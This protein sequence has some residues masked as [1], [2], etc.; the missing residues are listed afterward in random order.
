MI[1]KNYHFTIATDKENS[2]C[3][4]VTSFEF[5]DGITDSE[6]ENVINQK[7]S[8]F[9]LANNKGTYEELIVKEHAAPDTHN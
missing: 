5:P 3:K 6:I 2:Q 9:V 1:V 7:Y 8:E 4:F